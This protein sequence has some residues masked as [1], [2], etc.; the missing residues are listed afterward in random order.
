MNL[1]YVHKLLI[2]TDQQRHGFL[3]VRGRHADCAVRL[4]VSAGLVDATFSDSNEQSFTVIK[5]VTD[6]GQAFLRAFKDYQFEKAPLSVHGQM[7]GP[8]N[9]FERLTIAHAQAGF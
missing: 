2:A 3:R 6:T 7:D 8:V 1:S 9:E 4:M 5:R